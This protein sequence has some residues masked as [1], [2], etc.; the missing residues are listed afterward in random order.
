M[1]SLP[2][3]MREE[4]VRRYPYEPTRA[5]AARYGLSVKAVHRIA[6]EAR[7]RKALKRDE[8]LIDEAGGFAYLADVMERVR[9]LRARTIALFYLPD[10]LRVVAVHSASFDQLLAN[11]GEW[12][13]GVYHAWALTN[14]R[15]RE[16]LTAL[17][18][19]RKGQAA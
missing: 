12:L 14:A 15:L 4:L 8:P 18:N 16:D 11:H 19:D 5:L 17:V 7:V 10:E 6:E 9:R 1:P 3:A 13:V 2:V